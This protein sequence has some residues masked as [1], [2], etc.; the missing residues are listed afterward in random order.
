MQFYRF[1]SDDTRGTVE[2]KTNYELPVSKHVTVDSELSLY[3]FKVAKGKKFFDIINFVDSSTHFAISNRFKQLLE[4]NGIVGWQTIP[5]SIEDVHFEYFVFIPTSVV[6]PILNLE[7]VNRRL[8]P[9]KFDTSTWDGSGIFTL[10]NTL[11]YACT[12]SVKNLIEKA[13]ITNVY[14]KEL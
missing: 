12:D 14:L 13:N 2:I 1:R 3:S 4:D 11:I 9:L 7:M 10:Q 5:I 8:E 6:G